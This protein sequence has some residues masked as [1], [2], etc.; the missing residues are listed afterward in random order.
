MK[1]FQRDL[2][3]LKFKYKKDL[4]I[5]FIGQVSKDIAYKDEKYKKVKLVIEKTYGWTT[6]I[7]QKLDKVIDKVSKIIIN[8]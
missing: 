3:H 6:K 2:E 4:I 7:L 8:K 1:S 5:Q